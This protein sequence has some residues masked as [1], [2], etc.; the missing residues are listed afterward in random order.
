MKRFIFIAVL[1]LSIPCYA[2]KYDKAAEKAANEVG[3]TRQGNITITENQLTDL[4]HL[5][6]Q[7]T[8]CD[9]NDDYRIN[10]IIKDM[11]NILDKIDNSNKLTLDDRLSLI[12]GEISLLKMEI[13]KLEATKK[14]K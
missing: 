6:A 9:R 1:L 11:T 2:N 7:I 13:L 10:S 14:D 12:Q 5:I 8:M 4:R 3:S